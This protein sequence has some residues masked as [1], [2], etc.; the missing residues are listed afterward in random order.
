MA[1]RGLS[2]LLK[3]W[4]LVVAVSWLALA[5]ASAAL[6]GW[7]R[8]WGRRFDRWM[9]NEPPTFSA[10]SLGASNPFSATSLGAR[11]STTSRG[12]AVDVEATLSDRLLSRYSKRKRNSVAR[13]I[14]GSARNLCRHRGFLEIPRRTPN[15]RC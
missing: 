13:F 3:R 10:T 4:F 15:S 1:V 8:W 2:L 11:F 7:H 9:G 6:N 5:M 12:I 14:L